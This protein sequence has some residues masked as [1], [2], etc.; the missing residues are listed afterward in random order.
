LKPEL[1]KPIKTTI[2]TYFVWS[3]CNI[4][5]F[6]P[7]AIIALI[8]SILTIR[9][10]KNQ[11]FESATKNSTRAKYFNIF[12]DITAISC[13]FLM[14]LLSNENNEQQTCAFKRFYESF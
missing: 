7:F 10:L 5:S 11:D 3:I 13:F 4:I 9:N 12:A 8:F 14:L 6:L 2:N 1:D